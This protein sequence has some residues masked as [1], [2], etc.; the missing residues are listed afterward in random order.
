MR[1]VQSAALAADFVALHHANQ[2]ARILVDKRS[3]TP[4]VPRHFAGKRDAAIRSEQTCGRS[5]CRQ[6]H[7]VIADRQASPGPMPGWRDGTDEIK[8]PVVQLQ[9]R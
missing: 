9:K 3:T 5:P 8:R 6:P 1:H 2:A 7:F 4:A